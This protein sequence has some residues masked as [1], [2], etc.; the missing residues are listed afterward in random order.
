[1]KDKIIGTSAPLFCL[2][3]GSSELQEEAHGTTATAAVF[4]E[5]LKKS[6]QGAWQL[7]PLSETHLEPGSSTVH[8]S[9]PYKG[10]GIGLDPRW[11]SPEDASA[12]PTEEEF[13]AFTSTERDWID[14]Y[15]FFCALRDRFGTDDWTSWEKPIRLREPEAMR[16]WKETLKDDVNAHAVM[17]WRCH[18]AF[19]RLRETARSSGILILGDLPFYIPVQSPFVWAHSDRFQLDGEGKMKKVSGLPDSDK[20]HFG[21]QVWGHPLYDWNQEEGV[22]DLW[23]FRITYFS[24]FYDMMRLDHAKGFFHYGSMHATDPDRDALAEGPGRKALEDVIRHARTCSLELYAEDAGDRLE[25][26]RETLHAGGVPGIRIL[27]FAY[28][29]KRK[30]IETDYA[31]VANYPED[32][33]TLTSTHD[34]I[35]LRAYAEVLT[36]EERAHVAEHVGIETTDDLELFTMRLIEAGVHSPSRI[37]LVQMQDWLMSTARTNVPGTETPTGDPNWRYRMEKPIEDLPTTIF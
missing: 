29:E 8:V 36:P 9:S 20:A 27:R 19:R 7:L 17:Q 35:P 24:R 31:D 14:D 33:L 18:R 11:L 2:R 6:G 21:R 26:L 3:S 34:T 13:S 25:E 15:A 37:S 1:M 32:S 22:L 28:N 10:Y 12:M 30:S 5:W 4:L 23:K 16:T